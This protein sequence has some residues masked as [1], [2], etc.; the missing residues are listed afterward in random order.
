MRGA[1]IFVA[2]FAGHPRFAAL[3]ALPPPDAGITDPAELAAIAALREQLFP[4]QTPSQA[5][6]RGEAEG[7]PRAERECAQG[8]RT[9]GV[10]RARA[11]HLAGL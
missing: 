4:W 6:N 2:M 8:K 3:R 11:P 5:R 9:E 1:Q 10:S 7:G